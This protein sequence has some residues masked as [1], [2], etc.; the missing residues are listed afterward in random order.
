METSDG[1]SAC[2]VPGGAPGLF[3]DSS[4]ETSRGV[5]SLAIASPAAQPGEARRRPGRPAASRFFCPR[6]AGSGRLGLMA[7]ASENPSEVDRLLRRAEAGDP[8]G[9]RAL[10]DRDRDRLRRMV[11]LRMDRRLQGRIDA[12]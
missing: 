4:L 3:P 12:S 10:F 11:A 5:R 7:D 2:Q 6:A 1:G 8:E 9:W